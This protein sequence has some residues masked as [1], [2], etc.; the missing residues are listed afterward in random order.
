MDFAKKQLVKYGWTEGKGLGRNEDGISTALKPKL[1]FDNSGIGHNLSDEF[2]NNWWEK[3]FNSACQNIDV[4]VDDDEV[5]INKI[6]ATEPSTSKS[7]FEYGSFIKTSKLT[8]KGIED[9]QRPSTSNSAPDVPIIPLTDDE[10]FAACGGRTAHKGA[11]HGLKL[12]GKLSRIEKQEKI[13]LKKLKKISLNE[14]CKSST[15]KK[16]KKIRKVSESKSRS[17]D[18]AD[19]S[20]LSGSACTSPSLKKKK[21]KSVS[22]SERTTTKY[23]VPEPG[24]LDTSFDS[25]LSSLK[26]ENSNEANSSITFQ[27]TDNKTNEPES[28]ALP[29]L[30]SDLSKA[31]RKKLKKKRKLEAQKSRSTQQFLTLMNADCDAETTEET[32]SYNDVKEKSKKRKFIAETSEYLRDSKR[33]S[34]HLDSD[35]VDEDVS[36]KKKKKKRKKNRK[37]KDEEKQLKSITKSLNSIC[38]IS[39]DE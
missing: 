24:E 9:Y 7:R 25:E 39:D 18:M 22:F 10:L 21:R 12:N 26:D 36:Q 28:F 30:L 14:D 27:E 19:T 4:Q 15:E 13:L 29:K 35:L 23:Y 31:E 11:R 1:K 3:H 17:S 33:S 2:T 34:P 37:C 8:D 38:K 20:P 6:S 32:S 16:L 5:K